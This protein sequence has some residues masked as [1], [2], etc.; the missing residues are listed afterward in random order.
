MTVVMRPRLVVEDAAKAIEFYVRALGA[1][2]VGERH[3]IDGKIVH[4]ELALGDQ[5]FSVK[6]ADGDSGVM[7]GLDTEDADGAYRELVE[8]GATVVFP[9]GDHDYGLRQGR[10]VDPFGHVWIISQ[11]I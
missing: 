3:V 6:D 9:L 4:A 10:V 5:V 1:V 7:F 11:P 8:A 2:E